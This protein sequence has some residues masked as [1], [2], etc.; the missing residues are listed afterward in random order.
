MYIW[1]LEIVSIPVK[2]QFMT[3]NKVV[4]DIPDPSKRS[5]REGSNFSIHNSPNSD[6]IRYER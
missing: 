6:M 2:L 1:N 3:G 4:N 5:H